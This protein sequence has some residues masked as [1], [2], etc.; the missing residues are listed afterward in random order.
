MSNSGLGLLDIFDRVEV[1][2]LRFIFEADPLRRA[3]AALDALR[4]LADWGPTVIAIDDVQWLD[5]TSARALRYAL[6]RIEDA[7]SQILV[8]AQGVAAWKSCHLPLMRMS[9]RPG[10]TSGG[11]AGTWRCQRSPSALRRCRG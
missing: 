3:I 4:T 11:I 7:S 8:G 10:G 6:R 2:R 9:P 5:A 1:N